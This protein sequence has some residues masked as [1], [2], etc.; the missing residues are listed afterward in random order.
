MLTMDFKTSKFKQKKVRRQKF[1]HDQYWFISYTEIY[2]NS[3]ERDFK[4]IVKAR[5]AEL[6][7]KILTERLEENDLFLKVKSFTISMIHG[8]WQ[9]ASLNKPLSISQW[10]SIRSISFPNDWNKLFKFEKERL[11]GQLTRFNGGP[12]NLSEENKNRLRKAVKNLNKEYIKNSFKPLCPDLTEECNSEKYLKENKIIKGHA[13]FNNPKHKQ[14]ELD[15]IKSLMRKCGGNIQYASEQAGVSRSVMRRALDRF[16]KVDW[17]KD[18]PLTFKRGQ[19]YSFTK[20]PEYKAKMSKI[21]KDRKWRPPPNKKGT[22]AYEKWKKSITPTLE[23]K[24]LKIKK[25]HKDNIIKFMRETGFNRK[26][27][28]ELMGISKLY[29]ENLIYRFKKEDEDFSNEFCS[30]E[31]RARNVSEAAKKRHLENRINFFKDNK[32][33]ILQAYHQNGQSDSKAAKF[34][35]VSLNTFKNWKGYLDENEV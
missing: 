21:T 18:F 6:A 20:T 34:L 28:A 13:S 31:I 10:E 24:K 33:S 3:K 5:S 27:T 17:K 8:K 9:M 16:P 19:D 14:M 12:K 7:R 32:F 25:A 22:E 26:K 1:A 11:K 4:T 30:P 2:K 29:L 35:N 23:S 15:F